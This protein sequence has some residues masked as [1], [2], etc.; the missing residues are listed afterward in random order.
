[1]STL[2]NSYFAKLIAMFGLTG[3]MFSGI[4]GGYYTTYLFITWAAN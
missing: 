4:A 1:M 2:E 3:A